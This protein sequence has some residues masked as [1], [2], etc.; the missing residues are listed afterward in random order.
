MIAHE[1]VLEGELELQASDFIRQQELL[2]RTS[3]AQKE[4]FFRSATPT[5]MSDIAVTLYRL[6]A[7]HKAI[8]ADR[9]RNSN[10]AH[11]LADPEYRRAY[12]DMWSNYSRLKIRLADLYAGVAL[13]QE[14]A[15]AVIARMAAAG[16][17]GTERAVW[18]HSREADNLAGLC[19]RYCPN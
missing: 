8:E 18:F 16:P 17:M 14:R 7:A 3:P 5:E 15:P 9:L 19:L 1:D 6:D 2:L 13:R 10:I 4:E 12:T 11:R